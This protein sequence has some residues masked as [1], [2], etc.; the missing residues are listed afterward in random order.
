MSSTVQI[1]NGV[2]VERSAGPKPAPVSCGDNGNGG[3]ISG[4]TFRRPYIRPVVR[5]RSIPCPL[6]VGPVMIAVREDKAAR[7]AVA[8]IA[9]LSRSLVGGDGT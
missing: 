4:E 1:G 6:L 2:R 5:L 3:M 8:E 7:R 9:A